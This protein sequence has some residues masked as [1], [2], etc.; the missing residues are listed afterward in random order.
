M[1]AILAGVAL[2]ACASSPSA[3]VGGAEEAAQ[4]LDQSPLVFEGL[5]LRAAEEAGPDA[6]AVVELER[7]HRGPELE[8]LEGQTMPVL[9]RRTGEPRPG[10][11]AIFFA[12]PAE[13]GQTVGAAEVGH[14]PA[15]PASTGRV[16]ELLAESSERELAVRLDQAELVVFGEVVGRGG[17]ELMPSNSAP[18]VPDPLWSGALIAVESV[19]KG[20]YDDTQQLL[21]VFPA[22]QVGR[23]AAAP[24]PAIGQTGVWLLRRLRPPGFANYV[25]TVPETSDVREARD[26]ESVRAFLED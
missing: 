21:V 11:L 1:T 22:S 25:W 16:A 20:K 6:I 14:L 13:V 17:V 19:E 15:D 18:P 2:S 23:W 24:K 10:Q 8:G 3:K 12:R 26:L 9:L 4:W 7:I 5:V